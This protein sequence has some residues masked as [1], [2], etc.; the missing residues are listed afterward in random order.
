MGLIERGRLWVRAQLGL[1]DPEL[2][3][4]DLLARYDAEVLEQSSDG[5]TL[6]VKVL[7]ERFRDLQDVELRAG[8]AAADVRFDA[9]AKVLIGW[10]GGNPKLPY[11]EPSWQPGV[12]VTKLVLPGDVVHL[13][14]EA[15]SQFVALANLVQSR[16]NQLYNAVSNAAVDAQGAILKAAFLTALSG[17]TA[18][19]AALNTK[20]K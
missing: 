14:A 20:A 12:H 5:K 19:V 4:I 13:G 7:D 17:I 16:F 9:G 6:K 10:K 8:I 1:T 11:A 3:Q 18:S 2:P 15:G